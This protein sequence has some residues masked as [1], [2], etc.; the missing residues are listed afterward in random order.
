MYTLIVTAKL[1]DVD[2]QA[3]VVY[4]I[5]RITEPPHTRVHELLPPN[6]NT[7]GNHALAA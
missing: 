4:V 2:P 5:A 7:D 3:R 6:W 1:N